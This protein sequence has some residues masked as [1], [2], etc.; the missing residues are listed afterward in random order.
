MKNRLSALLVLIAMLFSLRSAAV[1]QPAPLEINIMLSMTGPAA[2]LGNA[3]FAAFQAAEKTV[4]QH[5]GVK[6]RPIKIVISDD[7]SSPQVA[8]QLANAF[9]A[10]VSENDALSCGLAPRPTVRPPP[11]PPPERQRAVTAVRASEPA[12]FSRPLTRLSSTAIVKPAAGVT[13][14]VSACVDCGIS[15]LSV[16]VSSISRGL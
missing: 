16:N 4:N 13:P 14:Q 8:L 7:A 6:G 10:M 9:I 11:E 12:A 15:V 1:A 3:E 2:F 5:G